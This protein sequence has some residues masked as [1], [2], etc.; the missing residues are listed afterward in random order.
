MQSSRQ[1]LVETLTSTATGFILSVAVWEFVVKPVWHVQTS[2]VENISIT[3]LFT[4]VSVLRGFC[5]RRFFNLL[6]HKNN[7]KEQHEDFG[8]GYGAEPR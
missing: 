5:I 4:A 3:L 7:K 2:F 1:S 8:Q 6:T